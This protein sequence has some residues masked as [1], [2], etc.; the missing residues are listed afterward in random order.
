[1][2]HRIPITLTLDE[3]DDIVDALDDSINYN[4]GLLSYTSYGTY[5]YEETSNRKQRMTDLHE[6]L[7]EI[8]WKGYRNA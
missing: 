4:N 2:E 8:Y 5:D 7:S 6:K 3:I 1:M